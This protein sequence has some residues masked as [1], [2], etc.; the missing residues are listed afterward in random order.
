MF[1]TMW[2]LHQ[3]GAANRGVCVDTDGAMLGPD[4]ALVQRTN[5]GHRPPPRER[6]CGIQRI[7][8]PGKDDP[9]W[10]YHQA[11]R[12]ADAL[13]RGQIAFA[14]IYGLRIPIGELGGQQLERLAAI[15]KLTKAGFNPDE[16]RIPAGEPGGGEW[17][18][19]ADTG[20]TVPDAEP[21]TNETGSSTPAVEARLQTDRPD[22]G[23]AAVGADRWTDGADA[24]TVG[25]EAHLI[26]AGYQLP[27][28]MWTVVR[29]LYRE[30]MAHGGDMSYLIKY[31]AD[32]G[33]QLEE[34]PSVIRS[35][36]DGP[37]PLAE[38]QTDKPPAGFDKESQLKAYLGDPPPGYEWH[39]II[40]Q[41]GQTRPDLTSP[42]GVQTWI[43]NTDNVV[44]APVI[45]H[46]C[47]NSL[48]SRYTP[49]QS[50]IRFR[51]T[52]KTLNGSDQR[53][54]GLNLLRVCGVI[55]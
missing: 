46:Y 32:H 53:G 33:L 39:H 5:G 42:E 21:R 55:K 16:P 28:G 38:L 3:R 36:F 13:E 15:A 20:V 26:E 14:Q 49:P 7:V 40:E 50:G 27:P 6:A 31:L 44:L 45:K 35:L 48:M 34:L 30:F 47:I 43:Q 25:L 1:A 24:G 10:L 9:D 12:I 51:D 37:K 2:R 11:Q 17:T 4:C 8:L 54:I 23:T 22:T 18:D 19:G 41:N 52:V 29:E